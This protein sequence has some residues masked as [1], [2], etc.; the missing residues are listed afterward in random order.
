MPRDHASR[1]T[2]AWVFFGLGVFVLGSAFVPAHWPSKDVLLALGCLALALSAVLD[3]TKITAVL[4]ARAPSGR[5]KVLKSF[6][7]IFGTAAL[8]P[9][10]VGLALFFQQEPVGEGRNTYPGSLLALFALHPLACAYLTLAASGRST[11]RGGRR[12]GP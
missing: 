4:W 10:I 8:V 1:L 6:F 5:V 12:V 11:K 2:L 7:A 9:A 3:R